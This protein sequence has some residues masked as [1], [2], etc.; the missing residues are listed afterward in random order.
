[1]D[2]VHPARLAV[3]EDSDE[4]FALLRRAIGGAPKARWTSGEDALED[5]SNRRV[6]VDVIV[7]DLALPGI[8]GCE[9][10]RR[11]RAVDG[12]SAPAICIL[13]GS[14]QAS[15]MQRAEQAGADGYLVKPRDLRGLRELPARLAE[16]AAGRGGTSGAT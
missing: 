5:L 10:V 16:I 13:S 2:S 8:D 15:D 9:F 4:D 7:V 1:M 3:V 12:G 11:A 14:A 6:D